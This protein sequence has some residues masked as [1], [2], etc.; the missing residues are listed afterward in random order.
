MGVRVRVV[1][2]ERGP[3]GSD[4]KVGKGQRGKGRRRARQIRAISV[5][6][7]RD[8][9]VETKEPQPFGRNAVYFHIAG[10][11]R[12]RAL[13]A[14]LPSGSAGRSF[15]QHPAWRNPLPRK[16][17]VMHLRPYLRLVPAVLLCAGL[18][19]PAGRAATRD[20]IVQSIAGAGVSPVVGNVHGRALRATDLGAAE[21]SLPISN[22]TMPVQP[23]G[24]APGCVDAASAAAAAAGVGELRADG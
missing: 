16:E 18:L 22:M 4:N 13:L 9:G 10:R 7:G 6:V 19:V 2:M 21:A 3:F 11:V 14:R 24:G 8:Q 23:D 15:L 5:E 17:G 12:D 1:G 20:R